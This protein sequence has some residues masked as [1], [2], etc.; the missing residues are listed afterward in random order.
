MVNGHVGGVHKAETQGSTV[1]VEQK[2]L[3]VATD[4]FLPLL[5]THALLG[6]HVFFV[7]I[8]SLTMS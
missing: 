7:L 4:P 8:L 5:I 1:Q 6:L 2:R 3:V